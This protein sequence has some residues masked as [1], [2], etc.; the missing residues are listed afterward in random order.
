MHRPRG[1]QRRRYGGGNQPIRI[2]TPTRPT[3]SMTPNT[4]MAARQ[5]AACQ[6][7][8]RC[9]RLPV[10]RTWASIPPPAAAC[11]GAGGPLAVAMAA[12]N[13]PSPPPFPGEE[14]GKREGS[15][16]APR[17]IP[18]PSHR[19]RR[20]LR[21]PAC[22]AGCEEKWLHEGAQAPGTVAGSREGPARQPSGGGFL[23]R[24]FR[25]TE[26]FCAPRPNPSGPE[27]RGQ[28]LRTLGL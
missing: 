2:H 26:T 1:R 6:A 4:G 11:P 3:T 12:R 17:A 13:C 22:A 15:P 20:R 5:H 28:G 24:S 27:G 25:E 8:S 7:A 18:S 19:R 21:R 16:T 23:R 10:G 9:G 14:G